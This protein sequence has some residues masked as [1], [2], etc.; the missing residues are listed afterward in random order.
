MNRRIFSRLGHFA[1]YPYDPASRKFMQVGGGRK[2]TL[3]LS[4][5][6]RS[7]FT[8]REA[9]R[10]GIVPKVAGMMLDRKAMS[11]PTADHLRH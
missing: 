11:I 1:R 4:E 8:F 10:D 9:R 7:G 5:A 3:L 6:R 2:A